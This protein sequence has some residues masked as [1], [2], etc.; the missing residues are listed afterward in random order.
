MLE[1]EVIKRIKRQYRRRYRLTLA[2]TNDN[3]REA[4]DVAYY[5]VIYRQGI[6]GALRYYYGYR[7]RRMENFLRET[8]LWREG[9]TA[10]LTEF[11]GYTKYTNKE[12]V[13]SEL[14]YRIFIPYSIIYFTPKEDKDMMMNIHH[15]AL[16]MAGFPI[17]FDEYDL[18]TEILDKIEVWDWNDTSIT[19]AELHVYKRRMI[20]K[21]GRKGWIEKG[22]MGFADMMISNF[23]VLEPITEKGYAFLEEMRVERIY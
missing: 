17:P 19:T 14:F 23:S 15:D 5:G 16:E 13:V 18:G 11:R 8:G 10:I 2:L 9:W 21:R 3:I 12:E 1:N 22:Y 20:V 4:L 7:Y 6:I